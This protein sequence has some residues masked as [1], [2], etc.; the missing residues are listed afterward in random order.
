MKR[1][2]R[3]E[4]EREEVEKNEKRTWRKRVKEIE[5]RDLLIEKNF[6]FSKL[7]TIYYLTKFFFIFSRF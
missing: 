5:R 4:N 1:L 3:K 7:E 6:L 2:R